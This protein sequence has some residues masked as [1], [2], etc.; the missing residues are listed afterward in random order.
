M[1]CT[2]RPTHAKVGL[3]L[4]I[5][6]IQD[7]TELPLPFDFCVGLT[8]NPIESLQLVLENCVINN[9]LIC[10]APEV[11]H[12]GKAKWRQ[13]QSKYAPWTGWH[14]M[15][16][17]IPCDECNNTD[18][19][20]W[21]T[22]GYGAMTNG[23]WPWEPGSKGTAAREQKQNTM[24]NIVFE[25]V[26]ELVGLRT[27][28]KTAVSLFIL[29]VCMVFVFIGHTRPTWIQK[30][31]NLFRF[32]ARFWWFIEKQFLFWLLIR[33]GWVWCVCDFFFWVK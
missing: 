32:R 14:L 24:L 5:N 10:H 22:R 27:K 9:W 31:N 1:I 13:P 4:K 7:I 12:L 23:H 18:E 11:A 8:Q 20:E 17:N 30:P 16:R 15:A 3:K 33:F 26:D 19:F 25:R 21:N 2:C 29:L 28:F 6:E